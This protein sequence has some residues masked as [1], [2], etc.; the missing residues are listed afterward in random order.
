M[1]PEEIVDRVAREVDALGLTDQKARAN[2][3]H[4]LSMKYMWLAARDERAALAVASEPEI[5]PC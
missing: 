2:V 3:A 5:T 1:T 4:C